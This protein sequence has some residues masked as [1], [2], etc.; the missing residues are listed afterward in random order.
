MVSVEVIARRP[1]GNGIELHIAVL[2]DP[3]RPPIVSLRTVAAGGRVLSRIE[4]GGGDLDDIERAL[5][6]L[7]EA[8]P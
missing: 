3:R 1:R 5:D 8:A 4:L 6:A 7:D 2:R